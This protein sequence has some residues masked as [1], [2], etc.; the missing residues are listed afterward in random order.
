MSRA[1][2]RAGES[3]NC[4]TAKAPVEK[5]TQDED[6]ATVVE[7][8]I[9]TIQ[10]SVHDLFEMLSDLPGSLILRFL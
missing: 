5:A 9:N 2:I 4:E 7:N 6:L 8:G 1:E 3:N 10:K